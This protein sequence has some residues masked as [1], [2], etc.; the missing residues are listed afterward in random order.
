MERVRGKEGAWPKRELRASK[1]RE[2]RRADERRLDWDGW[3]KERSGSDLCQSLHCD[4]WKS[5][6][7]RR[8]PA[9]CG[10][11]TTSAYSDAPR[12]RRSLSIV[13]PPIVRCD[14][15]PTDAPVPPLLTTIVLS[16]VVLI[17]TGFTGCCCH[18]S[19]RL[20]RSCPTTIPPPQPEATSQLETYLRDVSAIP[21]SVM[22]CTTYFQTLNSHTLFC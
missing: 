17:T 15:P 7:K 11:L 13:R 14:S 8:R 4:C 6:E 18:S 9:L 16:S 2:G 3:E 19:T 1:S 10:A 22:P 12:R 21:L 5:K 20:I